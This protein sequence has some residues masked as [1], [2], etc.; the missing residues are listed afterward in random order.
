[1][2]PP[3]DISDAV[4]VVSGVG[5]CRPVEE[6]MNEDHEIAFLRALHG[7][8]PPGYIEVRVIVDR[9]GGEVVTRAWYSTVDELSAALPRLRAIADK[10]HAGIFFGVLP[11]RERGAGRAEDMLPGIAVWADLDFKRLEG[12]EDEARARVATLPLRP[13]AIVLSGHGLHPYYMVREPEAPELLSCLSARLGHALSGDRV[14]D[15]PRI[16]RMPG[17]MNWKDPENPILAR[18][19]SWEPS[20][21]YNPSDL[22]EILPALPE[23]GD[24]TLAAG[25]ELTTEPLVIGTGVPP[26]VAALIAKNSR[27]R[28][29][30]EGRGK[31]DVDEHG[32]AMDT[33]SSGYDMSFAMSLA[34]HGIRDATA[35]AT[36]LWHRPD[37]AARSK[38]LEY[39]KRTV[40]IALARVPET[41]AR[42]TQKKRGPVELDFTVERVRVYASDPPVYEFL[43]DGQSCV[44]AS[45][46]ILSERRFGARFFEK[47]LRVPVTPGDHDQ[48]RAIV[49]GWMARAETI[50]QPPEASSSEM[51]REEIQR[52]IDDAGLG[53]RPADLDR[54]EVVEHD[55]V[56]VF[57]LAPLLRQLEQS[58]DVTSHSIACDLRMLGFVSRSVRI[59]EHVVR[60]WGRFGDGTADPVTESSSNARE[61]N[62]DE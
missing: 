4:A 40:Q 5:T 8:V 35:L 7:H 22:D 33:T 43:I 60:V 50:E 21:L 39:V 3:P 51:V 37:D 28:S 47:L 19:D 29:L 44:F 18:L 48:W 2:S 30:F 57:K 56:R 61:K 58:F 62:H 25:Q 45:G 54:G 12:G 53:E 38:G 24:G 42:S 26:R 11:R 59:G 16:L 10:R 13:T 23:P 41:E 32:R 46:E 17:T 1:M 36:A 31:P 15:T 34:K 14:H 27:V 20:Y 55:G 52:L 49:N 9:K 6:K